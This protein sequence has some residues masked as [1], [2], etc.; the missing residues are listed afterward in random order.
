MIDEEIIRNK[1]YSE[2]IKPTNQD[3]NYIGIEIRI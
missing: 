2:F 3:K 1:L